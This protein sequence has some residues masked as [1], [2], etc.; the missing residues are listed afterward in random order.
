MLAA[1]RAFV[2]LYPFFYN[3]ATTSS[4]STR[5]KLKQRHHV[6]GGYRWHADG[7]GHLSARRSRQSDQLNNTGTA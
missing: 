6:V 5:T 7:Q 3:A 2:T 1:A 4:S